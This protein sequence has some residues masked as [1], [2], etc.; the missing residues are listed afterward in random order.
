MGSCLRVVGVLPGLIVVFILS[1]VANLRG[2]T[3]QSIALGSRLFVQDWSA[4][5]PALM[6][7]DGLGPLFNAASCASC[8]NQ[9]GIGGGGEAAH[10]AKTLNIESM[11]VVGAP[12]SEDVVR[13]F[14]NRFHPGFVDPQAGIV[15]STSLPHQGGTSRLVELRSSFNAKTHSEFEQPGGSSNAAEVR[16]SRESTIL[17]TDQVGGHNAVIQARMFQRN[18]TALFGAGLIDQVSAKQLRA[19]ERAQQRHPEI[20]GRVATLGNGRIGRFGWRGDV[21]DLLHFSERACAGEL[22]LQ[23]RRIEQPN[24]PTNPGYRNPT[25]DITDDQLRAI[26]DFIAALPAPTQRID[27]DPAMSQM[28]R[29]GY[30][31][32]N[33][34][35]CSVCHQENM[36]PATGLYSDLL[37]HDMGP[38]LYDL[39]PA[40]PYIV[41]ITP[42]STVQFSPNQ[43][44]EM[45]LTLSGQGSVGNSRYGGQSSMS[46]TST[47]RSSPN[48][49]AQ[50][51][52]GF[53]TSRPSVVMTASSYQFVA[54]RT[55]EAPFRLV[56][57]GTKSRI[58]GKGTKKVG[59]VEIPDLTNLS[60][61][62]DSLSQTFRG[63]GI[64]NVR[65]TQSNA[66]KL[67]IE[68]TNF[69]QEWRTPPLWGCS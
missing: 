22:G 27:S 30:E 1:S 4:Q 69:N 51:S 10:N 7:K 44:V 17:H 8:H 53:P 58:I 43:E 3:P 52:T 42:V 34:L 31:L 57:M 63:A 41:K 16:R 66:L 32:F 9:G 68:S 12:M 21:P 46:S 45:T 49:S 11:K 33:S 13:R 59:D 36:G 67:K 50:I 20:S 23:S 37:L 19:A 24:D 48:R 55:P 35:G 6:G 54:P 47:F 56:P 2:A 29:K 25:H 64:S 28:A 26:T 65:Q 40:D 18:T 14:L 61:N 60:S 38:K 62:N 15:N 5:N 39:N